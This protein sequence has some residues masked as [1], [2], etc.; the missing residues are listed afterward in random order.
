MKM[1]FGF[2]VFL[3]LVLGT[4]GRSTVVA[5]GQAKSADHHYGKFIW[6]DLVTTD[7]ATCRQFYGS[8]LGWTFQQEQRQGRTY[9]IARLGSAPV[10][11]LLDV[12]DLKD[13]NS[14][15]VSYMSVPDVDSVAEQVRAAGGRVLVQPRQV[16][17]GGRAA[18][19]ADPQGAP[20]GLA[21]LTAG[22]PGDP[23][24]PLTGRFFWAE[25]LA[26]DGP[27][28]LDFY[29]RLVGYEASQTDAS[30]NIEYFVLR[31]GRPRAG[32]FQ[33]PASAANVRPNW[34]PY[35]R[36]D[37]PAALAQKAQTLGGRV[38]LAPSPERRH[39]TLAIVADPSGAAL[40]LQKL[41]IS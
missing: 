1:R 13:A 6:N 41:P 5:G 27:Q 37:D 23:P 38:I 10:A 30:Q 36:V 40:A 20:L 11:G 39:G 34:L 26:K 14:Q 12:R 4:A 16:K 25:F 15:W 18:I 28:A 8:L 2:V 3:A 35:V 21:R 29:K 33:L 31:H 32:L 9:L 19:V 7:L 17:V 24:E 22:D